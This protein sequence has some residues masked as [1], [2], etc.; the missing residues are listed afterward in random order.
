MCRVLDVYFSIIKAQFKSIKLQTVQLL[1]LNEWMFTNTMLGNFNNSSNITQFSDTIFNSW[2]AVTTAIFILMNN[3]I[4]LKLFV[5]KKL[6]DYILRENK[7]H[8][9]A[10]EWFHTIKSIRHKFCYQFVTY[11][12]AQNKKI[13]NLADENLISWNRNWIFNCIKS[14]QIETQFRLIKNLTNN[15]W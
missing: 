5:H 15:N 3:D 8:S 11:A 9:S 10:N 13:Y 1:L 7:W 2:G 12:W 14:N 6:F 4:S